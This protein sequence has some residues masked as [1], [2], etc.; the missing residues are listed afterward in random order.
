LKKRKE[1]KQTL[2]HSRLKMEDKRRC[3]DKEAGRGGGRRR[4][5]R[6]RRRAWASS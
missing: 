6:R 5:R 1:K 2:R 3:L 4:R